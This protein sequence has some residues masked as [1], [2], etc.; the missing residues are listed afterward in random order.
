MATAVRPAV[1]EP[2]AFSAMRRSD[3]ALVGT[4]RKRLAFV[5]FRAPRRSALRWAAPHAGRA[6]TS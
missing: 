5:L 2:R 3:P 4:G 1:G 6:I